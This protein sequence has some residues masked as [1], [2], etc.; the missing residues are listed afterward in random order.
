MPDFLSIA[1]A[2]IAIIIAVIAIII[3]YSKSASPEGPKGAQGNP[4]PQGITGPTGPSQGPIGPTGVTGPTGAPEFQAYPGAV[5]NNGSIMNVSTSII[6][7]YGRIVYGYILGFIGQPGA[8][9]YGNGMCMLPGAPT[10]ALASS[11]KVLAGILTYDG[12][13]VTV[14]VGIEEGS[15][16][17]QLYVLGGQDLTKVGPGSY[18]MSINYVTM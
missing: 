16:G 9:G 2:I 3:V 6:V 11:G 13:D 5:A 7:R 4:G 12:A 18:A 17:Q 15:G 8:L 14:T 1:I 10:P